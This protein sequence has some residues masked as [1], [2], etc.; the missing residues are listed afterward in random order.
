M[1]AT[2]AIDYET[3]T[4]IQTSLRQALPSDVT[5]LTVA[6]RLQTIMDADKIVSSNTFIHSPMSHQDCLAS[7]IVL[8]SGRLV[9]CPLL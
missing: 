5:V 2:S 6:H 3:D 4:V 7:Q 9:G 8:D 1:I